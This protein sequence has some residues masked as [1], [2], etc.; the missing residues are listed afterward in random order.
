[1][2][3]SLSTYTFVKMIDY[4]VLK[5]DIQSLL[6]FTC[7]NKLIKSEY[8]IKSTINMLKKCPSSRQAVLVFY[9]NLFDDIIQKFIDEQNSIKTPRVYLILSKLFQANYEANRVIKERKSNETLPTNSADTSITPM[10]PPMMDCQADIKEENDELN[11]N[12]AIDEFI[13][14]IENALI[15]LIQDKE[16]NNCQMIIDWALIFISN[17]SSKYSI[18]GLFQSSNTNPTFVFSESIKFWI[19]CPVINLLLKLIMVPSSESQ[20]AVNYESILKKLIDY[21]PGSDW[22]CAYLITS[23]PSN[24]NLS[25]FSICI[26]SLL[27]SKASQTSITNILSYISEHNPQAIITASQSNIPFLLRLCAN[28]KPL[29]NLL[30]LEAVK[31]GLS[32]K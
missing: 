5:N 13:L 2:F 14:W 1:M 6:Q 27:Q 4:E 18:Q 24:S 3:L 21:S 11:M 25:L 30:A 15:E 28:S 9:S 19:K 12:E 16:F 22:I 29:L 17:L 8:I 23:L 32:F 26:H 7:E 31:Q 10:S 20:S